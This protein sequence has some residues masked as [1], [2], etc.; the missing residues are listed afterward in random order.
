VV[1]RDIVVASF[2]GVQTYPVGQTT[3]AVWTVGTHVYPVGHR[4]AIPVFVLSV[5]AWIVID[6]ED[7]INVTARMATNVTETSELIEVTMCFIF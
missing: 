2:F 3:A 5:A 1:G 6:V 7:R 4:T